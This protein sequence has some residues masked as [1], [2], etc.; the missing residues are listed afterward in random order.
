MTM[1]AKLTKEEVAYRPAKKERRCG[2]CTTFQPEAS[3]CQRVEGRI[4]PFMVCEKWTPL[5]GS[6]GREGEG[7]AW[8]P[9]R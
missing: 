3:T 6:S 9:S 8:A 5:K 2:N 4:E 1:V 7:G